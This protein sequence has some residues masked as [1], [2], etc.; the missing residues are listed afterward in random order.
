MHFH[1]ATIVLI[2][3]TALLLFLMGCSS[4]PQTPG[5]AV[6]ATASP[7]RATA[8]AGP[9]DIV[10]GGVPT[11]EAIPT[12]EAIPTDI[13]DGG[14]AEATAIASTTEY[15]DDR[16][17]AESVVRSLF[18][19]INSRQYVRAYSYWE[20]NTEGLPPF[21]EFEQSFAQTDYVDLFHIGDVVTETG[22]GQQ[23]FTVPYIISVR[24]TDGSVE[25][26]AGCYLL[27]LANPAIQGTPPFQ[28]MGIRDAAIQQMGEGDD[29]FT[30]SATLCEEIFAS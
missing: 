20:P 15:L 29:S 21:E 8:E 22:A 3:S 19:A 13:V 9:T 7:V 27:H 14:V 10:D 1:R 26:F 17:S 18:N 2:I 16:S 5:T 30:I 4:T 12:P 28:P 23:Y 25:A 6:E 11:L 24:N